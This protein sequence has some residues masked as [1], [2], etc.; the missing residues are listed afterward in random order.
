VPPSWIAL[1]SHV[2]HMKRGSP[3]CRRFCW[4]ALDAVIVQR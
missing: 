3:F 2:K 1:M 4:Q